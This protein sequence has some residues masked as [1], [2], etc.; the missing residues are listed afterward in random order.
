MYT[1][2]S[3]LSSHKRLSQVDQTFTDEDCPHFC[4][5]KSQLRAIVTMA[6]APAPRQT[7]AQR[8]NRRIIQG[9]SKDWRISRR[10]RGPR[11][12]DNIK[13]NCYRHSLLQNLLHLP[14]FLNWIRQHNVYGQNWPC[15][16]G[17]LP[18]VH[19]KLVSRLV[20]QADASLIKSCVPCLLK[21]LVVAYWR[22]HDDKDSNGDGNGK[23]ISHAGSKKDKEEPDLAVFPHEHNAMRPIHLF[24]GRFFCRKPDNHDAQLASDEHKDKSKV[25]KRALTL[26][27]CRDNQTA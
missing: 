19:D 7:Q 11:G 22:S 25:A 16:P 21:D 3:V 24:A 14:R 13:L 1:L 20:K 10:N 8:D 5:V 27:M 23:K 26:K 18:P 4:V 15:N 6:R 2:G 9:I 17:S 12:L